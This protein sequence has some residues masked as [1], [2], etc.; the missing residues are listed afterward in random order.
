MMVVVL[1][2]INVG[3]YSRRM[4]VQF[5]VPQTQEQ[6][7]ACHQQAFEYFHGVT[8]EVMV[9]NCKTAVLSHPYGQPAVPHRQQ[10]H[11]TRFLALSPKAREYYQ[12]LEEKRGNPRHHVQKIVALSEIYG[13]EK[14]KRS[15]EDALA[16]QAFSC[17]YNANILEQR[18]QPV[19]Q[20]GTLHLTR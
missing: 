16:Y 19:T 17:E 1:W 11:L 10:Q 6:F 8:A 18:E 7:L 20:P 2:L 4:Y 5:T 9:D 15:L 3:F 12:R 14:V 13:V